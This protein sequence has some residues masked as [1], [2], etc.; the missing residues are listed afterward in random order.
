[1]KH[2]LRL[3]VVAVFALVS[4]R[5]GASFHLIHIDEIYSNADG[6]LQYVVLIGDADGQ[7]FLAG[8]AITSQHAAD[9][10]KAFTFPNNLPSGSTGGRH[11]LIATQTFASL[12]LVTPDYVVPDRF[13]PTDGGTINYVLSQVTYNLLPTDGTLA[14]KADGTTVPNIATN[15][16]GTSAM[17]P[18]TPVTS[19]EFFNAALN[20][21]FISALAPDIDALDSG[22]I[23]GWVRTNLNFL[24]YPSQASGGA[25]A[26]P[27]CRILIPPPA[28]S[29][30]FS[31]SPQECADTLAKFPFMV[32][33]TDAAFYIALPVTTGPMAGTCPAL[34]VPVYRVFNNRPDGNHRYTTSRAIRDQM[35]ALG[36]TAEGYGDDAVIMCA[37]VMAIPMMQPPMMPMPPA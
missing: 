7:Q 9:P 25:G 18:P 17:V 24:V 20:H 29:H 15:F 19:V 34:T 3:F 28:D 8:H 30:F 2:L 10:Q 31:A 33:E 35:V 27:V 13:L 36:G 4:G 14:L 5:A 22:R 1:M 32:K 23:A 6:S 21:Y 16:S 26:S 12:G 11:I 37:P